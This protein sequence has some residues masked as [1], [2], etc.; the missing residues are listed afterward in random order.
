MTKSM[1]SREKALGVVLILL[2]LGLGWYML[3]FK[4]IQEK[5][6]DLQSQQST[7]QSQIDA[8]LVK[9]AKYNKA[10]EKLE[11]AK[12]T[13][14][15]MQTAIPKYDNIT[16]ILFELDDILNHTENY[17]VSFSGVSRDSGNT[18]IARRN[19]GLSFSCET[20]REFMSLLEDFYNSEYRCLVKDFSMSRS[21]NTQNIWGDAVE[22]SSCSASV[23]IVYYEYMGADQN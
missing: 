21:A 16:N 5:I 19:V 8:A 3:F 12:Q 1:T 6:S 10:L 9:K 20:Y 11:E 7:V 13:G 18:N 15:N 17:S 4:P 22:S 2:I 23:T 14:G